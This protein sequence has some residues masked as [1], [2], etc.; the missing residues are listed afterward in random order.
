MTRKVEKGE[1]RTTVA[2]VLDKAP[3]T[4]AFPGVIFSPGERTTVFNL[5]NIPYATNNAYKVSAIKV[6]FS[7]HQFTSENVVTPRETH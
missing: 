7:Q 6:R 1:G 5:S 4:K 2:I 3:V